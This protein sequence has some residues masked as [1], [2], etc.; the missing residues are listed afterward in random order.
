MNLQKLDLALDP[1]K[2][3][4]RESQ[5]NEGIR[6]YDEKFGAIDFER[7]YMPLFELLWYGQL[8]CT[9]VKGITSTMKD[10][11]AFIKK[12][13][14]KERSVNC[15]AI[16]QKRPTDRGMCCTFNMN[17]ANKVLRKSKYEEAVSL[18]QLKEA[19]T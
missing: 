17:K 13:Y 19:N 12:C 1:N 11:L 4:E 9:D 7:S 14:W 5:T 2:N 8:P 3:A 6:K 18:Q 15:N 16:F 10:E